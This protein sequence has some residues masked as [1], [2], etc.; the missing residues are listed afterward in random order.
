MK[1]QILRLLF[2]Q[3]FFLIIFCGSTFSLPNSGFYLPESV[4]ELTLR[5]HSHRNLIVLPVVINDSI[6]VNLVLDTGCR[7]LVL[8]GKKFQK[9]FVHE[10]GK[11]VQFSGL[12]SGG[13]VFGTVSLKNKVSIDAVL[14]DDIPVVIV[15]DKNI[16]AQYK[17][18]HG[19]IGY[20]IFTKFEIE[21]NPRQQLITFRP[22]FTVK[23]SPGYIHIPIRIEDSRPILDSNIQLDNSMHA[24][25]LMIDTGSSL[26]LLLKTTDLNRYDVRREEKELGLGLNGSIIGYETTARALFLD[27]IALTI[28]P[29]GIIESSWHNYASIGMG[30][31]KDYAI[32]LNYCK[33]YVGFRKLTA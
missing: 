6:R 20:D 25:N 31:L 4:Q 17:N 28:L 22:A 16:F 29:V 23:P 7:N 3:V 13:P 15:P 26:G 12:G 24:C 32:V 14:G 9:L 19:V 8:F 2:L 10:H 18:V 11:K 30:V 1:I 27:G 21:L 33:A 5:F